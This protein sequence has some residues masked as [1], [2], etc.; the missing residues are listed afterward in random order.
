MSLANTETLLRTLAHYLE[1]G[2]HPPSFPP[3]F[4]KLKSRSV[5]FYS[6]EEA[7]DPS[8]AEIVQPDSS[9]LKT[10]D[11]SIVQRISR[12]FDVLGQLDTEGA[13]RTVYPVNE[14]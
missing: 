12:E 7:G 10:A 11:Q 1:K 6:S 3:P 2:Q 5:L 4:S 9:V 8:T 13:S 14:C